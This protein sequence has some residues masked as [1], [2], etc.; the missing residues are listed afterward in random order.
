MMTPQRKKWFTPFISPSVALLIVG[1]SCSALAGS[2]SSA[3]EYL[4]LD[5]AQLMNVTVS[6]VAKRDQRL[7]DA[8]AAV[9]VISQD[10]I[11]RSGVTSVADAL[12]MAPGIQ[13][14]K[15]SASKWSVSSR[16]FAG[17][18]S[19]KLLVLID[20]RSVY[21]P[22]Y[23]GV[24]WDSNNVM[25]EDVERIEVVRGPGG[26]VWGANAVN[27]VINI[28]T[29]KAED[30]QG[31]LV[32]VGGGDQ[33]P[34]TTAARYGGKISDTAFGRFYA[35]YNDHDSNQLTAG[36]GDAN[37]DWQPMQGGFRLDGKPG[38]RNEWT[39]QGDLYKNRGDQKIA[40]Y[41]V[42][43]PPFQLSIDDDVDVS[44]GNL[45]GRWKQELT[46]DSALTVQAYID[47]TKRDELLFNWQYDTVD[48]DLQYETMLG[49]RQRLTLGGGYRSIQGEV[50]ENFQVW[51][52]D[53]NDVL[54]SAFVQ[55]EINLVQE[56][57]WLT[58]GSKYEHNDY[59]GSEW[60][61]SAKLLW[62]PEANHSLWTSVSRAV[63]TPTVLQ[64][65]ARIVVGIIP[66]PSVTAVSFAGTPGCEAEKLWAY[67]AGYRWQARSNLSFD[68]ALF[69]NDYEDLY[70][71]MP[72]A[73]S[74][75]I[76]WVNGVSG[77]N[78]GLELSVD[79]QA[80]S[81]LSF[82]LA[83]AYLDSHLSADEG[84]S[85]ELAGERYNQGSPQHQISLRT[86]IHLA[87][88]WR[89]NLWGRYID[90]ITTWDQSQ[91]PWLALELEDYLL[92][93]ANLI[94]TPT[95]HL[96]LMLAGQNLINSGQLQYRSEY[97]TPATEIERG[98][99]GK[100]TWR[101]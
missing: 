100:L 43:T 101:F 70:T 56:R 21:S 6:S 68:L 7:T 9:F 35:M 29:K 78:Q 13:V 39:L 95:R 16:G 20:G 5:I 57:L 14:A 50:N 32:R 61:P 24:F 64:R 94:W 98:V 10:D 82:I 48:L 51:A 23:S 26:T 92:L 27:G 38:T 2:D 3:N 66:F 65:D 75:D 87:D 15:I 88:N 91:Q 67:E 74:T 84:F 36:G 77:A 69:Y 60:Q 47:T 76:S 63:V 80:T 81:R 42:S 53:R 33:E 62:K 93:D 40:P 25:L 54:Y 31:G 30:T 83:Y 86:S 90:G 52:P 8:A 89:L 71:L 58:L 11:R 22:L 17:Y 1:C 45:L 99:Y 79:W 44:G 85:G 37:D 19:N 18:L 28:I 4:D 59:T 72:S 41:W 34:L 97:S 73:T 96:E 46:A 55:D 12:A 49:Q